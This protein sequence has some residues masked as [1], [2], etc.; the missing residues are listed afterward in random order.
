MANKI[1]DAFKEEG[2]L[3]ATQGSHGRGFGQTRKPRWT[4]LTN[5]PM[6]EKA[7]RRYFDPSWHIAHHVSTFASNDS[8]WLTNVGK[9][10]IDQPESLS[11]NLVTESPL[12]QHKEVAESVDAEDDSL[13]LRTRTVGRPTTIDSSRLASPI[14]VGRA[15]RSLYTKTPRSPANSDPRSETDVNVGRPV[16]TPVKRRMGNAANTPKSRKKFKMSKVVGAVDVSY[17][18]PGPFS[19]ATTQA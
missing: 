16:V 7:M 18:S 1:F 9:L 5:G 6:Y 15:S 17:I 8:H 10:A 11:R 2:L 3:K 19:Q 12:R 14:A 4:C 13:S